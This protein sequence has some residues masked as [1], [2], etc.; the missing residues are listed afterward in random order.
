MSAHARRGGARG[1][2]PGESEVRTASLHLWGAQVISSSTAVDSRVRAAAGTSYS[3]WFLFVLNLCRTGPSSPRTHRHA[4]APGMAT[5]SSWRSLSRSAATS[6]AKAPP[7]A[8]SCLRQKASRSSKSRRA[9]STARE[10]TSLRRQTGHGAKGA[11][12]ISSSQPTPLKRQR[13]TVHWPRPSETVATSR[14]WCLSRCASP[15]VPAHRSACRPSVGPEGVRE[16]QLGRAAAGPALEPQIGRPL[17][18]SRRRRAHT[19]ARRGRWRRAAAPPTASCGPWET[20]R[21]GDSSPTGR[22]TAPCARRGR[23]PPA[24]AS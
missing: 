2:A 24:P 9:E 13:A 22:S 6:C 17:G 23:T 5:P 14:A 19:R 15:G 7:A 16:L 4:R 18:S 8:A 21:R 11:A 12:A 10:A 1:Q 3:V 20:S